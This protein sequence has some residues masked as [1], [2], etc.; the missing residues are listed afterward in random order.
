MKLKTKLVAAGAIGAAAIGVARAI[1]RR[2]TSS[3]I[4]SLFDSSD[5]DEP[6]IITEEVIVITDEGSDDIE[7]DLFSDASR[8]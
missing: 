5:L 1:R 7:S 3:D 6:V 2:N 8:R 4:D